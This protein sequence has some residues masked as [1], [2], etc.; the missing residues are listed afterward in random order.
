MKLT[1][2]HQADVFDL[3]RAE[4]NTLLYH[5]TADRIFSTWEWLSTWWDAYQPG[6]LWVITCRD[7]AG[8]L[9]G[10]AP[11]F[12]EDHPVHGRVVR[13]IGC[14]DVTDYLDIILNTQFVDAVLECIASYI[15]QNTHK[16]DVIDLCNLP[17][18][19]PVYQRFPD[20]ASQHG[21]SVTTTQQEVCPVIQLPNKWEEYLESLDKKQRHELRRKLRRAEGAAE[22]VDWYIVGTEHNL[23]TEIDRFI[24]LMA[25]SHPEKAGFLQNVQNLD[26]FKKIVPIIY[27]NGWLQMCFLTIDGQATAAYLNF[28][29]NNHVLVYNSGLLPDH[30]GHLSPGIVLLAYNIRNAIESGRKVFDF[31]RGNEVYKYRMGGQDTRVYMLRAHAVVTTQG[32]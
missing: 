27:Q 11:W 18:D 19:S 9:I 15:A 2:Y 10:L 5:S 16:F 13:S 4:W 29:Y 26:F 25:A 28:V 3:L 21:F 22:K 8:Q 1:G 20:L 6:E 12:I 14:V 32:V 23:A 31:L 30:Y 24:H 7:D 17:E